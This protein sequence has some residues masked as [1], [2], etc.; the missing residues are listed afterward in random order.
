VLNRTRDSIRDNIRDKKNNFVNSVMNHTKDIPFTKIEK[1]ASLKPSTAVVTDKFNW[2]MAEG[3]H[4]PGS[5][6]D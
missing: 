4:S 6:K 5:G 3:M 1:R 2:L